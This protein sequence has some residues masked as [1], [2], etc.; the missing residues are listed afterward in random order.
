M[1]SHTMF[2]SKVVNKR[3][4]PYSDVEC[5]SATLTGRHGGRTVPL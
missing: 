5:T 3:F 4:G 2:G 1:F